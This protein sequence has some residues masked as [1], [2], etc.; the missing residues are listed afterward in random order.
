MDMEQRDSQRYKK[1]QEREKLPETYKEVISVARQ[2]VLE[3]DS[4]NYQ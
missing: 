4:S 2:R 1:E 3:A